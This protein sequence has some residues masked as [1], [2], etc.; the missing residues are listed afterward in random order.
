MT[1]DERAEKIVMRYSG[2]YSLIAAKAEIAAEIKSAVEEATKYFR[3]NDARY[4]GVAVL[5]AYADAVKIAEAELC[6]H[7]EITLDTPA[8]EIYEDHCLSV[9]EVGNKIRARAKEIL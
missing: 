7:G 4:L 6:G 2:Q 5:S 9:H 3:E 8:N 1:P